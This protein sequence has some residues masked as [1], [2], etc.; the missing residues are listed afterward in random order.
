MKN[1]LL[2]A[3]AAFASAALA[4]DQKTEGAA[5]KPA[6]EKPKAEAPILEIKR[7]GPPPCI[8]KPVMTDDEIE[9]CRRAGYAARPKP[10]AP[11][12]SR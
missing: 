4:Q 7:A 2:L 5:Q 9:V 3:I 8:V 11:E 1:L 6:A 10:Q 12:I